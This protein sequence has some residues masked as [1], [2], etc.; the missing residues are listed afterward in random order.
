MNMDYCSVSGLILAWIP[1][2]ARKTN[3]TYEEEISLEVIEKLPRF[4]E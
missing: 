1:R 3:H 2:N 4:I